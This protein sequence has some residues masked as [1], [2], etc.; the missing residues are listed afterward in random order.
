MHK[1][2]SNGYSSDSLDEGPIRMT[3][4]FAHS[5]TDFPGVKKPHDVA[6]VTEFIQ[7]SKIPGRL[8]ISFPGNGGIASALFEGKE[9]PV[10]VA[11]E[12]S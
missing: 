12:N 4:T 5:R 10:E 9:V 11:E 2:R 3:K 6:G 7:L 8:V 1:E